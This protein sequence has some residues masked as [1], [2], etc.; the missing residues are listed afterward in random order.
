MKI[1]RQPAGFMAVLVLTFA[2]VLGPGFI[3]AAK[4]ASEDV[5]MFYDDLS[6]YGEWV[7]YEKYGPVWRPGKVAEDWRPYTNGR[8]VPTNDGNVFESDEPWGWATYHYGN[9]MPTE[10]YGWVWVPGSTWYPSTVEW[11]SSPENEPVDNSYVGW[12]PTPPPDY[13]PPPAYAPPSYYQGA[14]VTDSLA[15]PLWIFAKAAS[16]LLGF[17]QS[18]TPAYSYVNSGVLVPPTYVPVF[19]SR[20]VF[21]P[22]YATP[23]YY[24]PAFVGPRRLGVGYYN[25]GPSAGYLSRVTR[26]NQT[27]I[28]RTINHNSIQITRIRNVVPPQAVVNR[29]GYVRQIIPPA[30]AQGRPLPP[31]QRAQN[32]RLAQVNLNR[33]NILPP[34]PGVPRIN[35]QIPRV[36][37]VAIPPSQGLPGTG[38]PSRATMPLTPHMTQQIHQLPPQQR[39]V[40]GQAKPFT[41]AT[42][43]QPGPVPRQ[44]GFQPRPG[45]GQTVEPR[46]PGQRQ[47]GFHPQTGPGQPATVTKPGE[48]VPGPPKP[49]EFRPGAVRPGPSPAVAPAT[50]SPPSATKPSPAPGSQGSRGLTP[51][52]RRPQQQEYQRLP[53]GGTPGQSPQYQ[54]QRDQERLRQQQR[55]QPERQHQMQMQQQQQSQ[56][57]QM[58]QRQQQL[59]QQ[60]QIQQQRQQQQIRPQPQPRPQPQA[61]PRVQPQPQPRPHPQQ[62]RQERGQQ[63]YKKPQEQQ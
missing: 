36:R 32:I 49:G 10:G 4:A 38:L 45:P 39:F 53:R 42:A 54:Q 16:F 25:M 55:Q 28:T 27:I 62:Q 8:W 6:Q 5:A 61:P 47:P 60:Q 12:A 31:P 43:T 34:P 20:T 50:P 40:P 30:L 52:P 33:P 41:P 2:L 3:G 57:L 29:Y 13:V 18:Y 7:E 35:A 15:S 23:S 9:W 44:P 17:G 59:R 14:P 51:E 22:A 1:S 46:Q 24:P 58:Q 21:I 63:Q 11:R 19:F 26:I 48:R 37:P 56:Q